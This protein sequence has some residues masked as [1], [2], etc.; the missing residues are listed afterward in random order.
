M[1]ATWA[2]LTGEGLDGWLRWL[3]ARM[4]ARTTVKA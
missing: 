2:A 4:G 3:R 1:Q